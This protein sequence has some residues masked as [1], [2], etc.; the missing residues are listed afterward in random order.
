VE[1]IRQNVPLIF[2]RHWSSQ[3]GA[4]DHHE[5][6]KKSVGKLPDSSQVMARM[7]KLNREKF[8][9]AAQMHD[10]RAE[11][12]TLSHLSVSAVTETA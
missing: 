1:L 6:G 11:Y 7:E 2:F 8:F 3:V 4:I 5:F 9:D 12:P 10:L